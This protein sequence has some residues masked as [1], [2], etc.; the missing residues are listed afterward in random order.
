VI[1]PD[2]NLLL[3]TYDTGSPFHRRSADWWQAC[4]SGTEPVGL[5]GVVLF[6]FVRIGT[7]RRAFMDPMTIAEAAAHVR[8]W[9]ARSVTEYLISNQSD[10]GRALAWLEEAA[11][12]AELT[13][14]AQVAAIADR[15]RAT[16]HT[17][18]TDFARFPGVHWH[19][20]LL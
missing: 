16:V 9:L 2:A 7:N 5:C 6:A 19:N 11:A 8:S 17:A 13:T 10:V 18:D 20:P 3:Y 15:H 1:V 12:G 14:D 4:L